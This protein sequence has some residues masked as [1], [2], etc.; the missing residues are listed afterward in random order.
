MPTVVAVPT[1]NIS[2]SVAQIGSTSALS[3]DPTTHL[4]RVVRILNSSQVGGSVPGSPA[5]CPV[6]RSLLVIA[7]SSVVPIAS[8]PP[9]V[10]FFF[11]FPPAMM[12]VIRVVIGTQLTLPICSTRRP[13]LISI[14]SPVR[15]TPSEIVPPITPPFNLLG[16]IPGRLT[17][18]DRATMRRDGL[19]GSVSGVGITSSSIWIKRSMLI[20][21]CADI[22]TIGA[23]SATVPLTNSFIDS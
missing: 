18:N 10:A 21:C 1:L 11:L 4:R 22:G 7:G 20:F 5:T 6:S 16:N 23:F 8:S 12:L 9:D 19:S 17:S 3:L 2:G 14:S 15:N 13:G